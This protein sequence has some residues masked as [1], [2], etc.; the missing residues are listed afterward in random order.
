[1]RKNVLL[2]FTLLLFSLTA[3]AGKGKVKVYDSSTEDISQYHTEESLTAVMIKR[4]TETN[5]ITFL[6]YVTGEQIT[7]GYHGGVSVTDTYGNNLIISDLPVGSV[8]D[9]TYYSDTQRLISVS[10]SDNVQVVK[11]VNKFSADVSNKKATYK[12]TSCKLSEYALAFEDGVAKSIME[13]N[14]ED[15][16]TLYLM[17]GTL[18]SCVIDIGHGYARLINQDT[19]VGGMVEIG[20]DVIVPVTQDML[21]AVREGTYTLRINNNGYASSKDVTIKKGEETEINIADIAIP[22]GTVNFIVTPAEA[23]VYVDGKLCETHAFTGLY[24][25]YGLKIKADGYKSF[26]GSIKISEPVKNHTFELVVDEDATTE[27][28]TTED[29]S[30]VVTDENGNTITV[31]SSEGTD[32]SSDDTTATASSTSEN[33]LTTATYTGATENTITVKTPVGAGVYVD[34]NYVGYAP[35]T[36]Q[37][38]VG[39]HTIVLYQTGSLIKSY[40]I[41]ATDDGKD[42]E[43]SF[44]DL[45]TLTDLINIDN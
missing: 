13:V 43:Y 4:D 14:T 30:E 6:N 24:G 3:C 32:N 28:D 5:D 34:G 45:T 17:N 25:S 9:I 18:I 37:K 44:D 16:V 20:Y 36:F 35:V 29:N 38:V 19:Y 31:T 12:G 7:L 1:M 40:T 39:T 21:I 15:Q 23:D 10:A 41:Q 33:D 2:I 42:D 11:N 27:E 26:N 22:S 8:V